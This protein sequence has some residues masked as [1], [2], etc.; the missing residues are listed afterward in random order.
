MWYGGKGH[1]QSVCSIH[2]S[3]VEPDRPEAVGTGA[4]EP[5]DCPHHGD[6]GLP[7]VDFFGGFVVDRSIS[8]N[9]NPVRIYRAG[10]AGI[11]PGAVTG[12]GR[13]GP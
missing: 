9:I 4:H 1:R 5:P 13:G 11:Y 10:T 6:Y 2:Q 7:A 3:G 8:Y 12:A